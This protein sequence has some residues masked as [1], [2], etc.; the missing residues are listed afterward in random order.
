MFD[1]TITF[2]LNCC[3]PQ[4]QHNVAL[5]LK[6]E[7][8]F[9]VQHAYVSDIGMTPAHMATFNHFYYI[10]LL[11]MSVNVVVLRRS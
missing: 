3:M 5:T 11:P 8:V 2:P 7:D 4:V 6:I 9:G 10:K 1:Y